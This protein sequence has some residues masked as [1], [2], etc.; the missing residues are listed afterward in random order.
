MQLEQNLV[1]QVNEVRVPRVGQRVRNAQQR[2]EEREQQL[3]Q[4]VVLDR[5]LAASETIGVR[6]Q[7]A[8]KMKR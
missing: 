4:L 2:F 6:I 8:T 7:N 5:A 1:V 3:E